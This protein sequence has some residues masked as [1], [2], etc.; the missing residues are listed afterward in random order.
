MAVINEKDESL[1]IRFLT[2]RDEDALR[3]LLERYRER[4][5]LFL[6]GYV[7]N[8]ED[9]ED[10]MMD[11]FAEAASKKTWSENGGSSF[12]TWLFAIGRKKALLHLRRS[13]ILPVAL[14]DEIED[15]KG[16]PDTDLLREERDRQ[17]Y[18]ALERLKPDYRQVL[19]L[20]YFEQMTHEETAQVMKKT[21]KQVYHLVSRGRERLKEILQETD[22][23]EL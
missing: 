17:L 19:V 9:A 16:L 15:E 13:R 2:E 10:L 6:Y 3:I 20:I 5:T 14:R 23:Q 8:M 18:Q 11:A 1:Y 21:K 7:H 4:L 22:F 12:K